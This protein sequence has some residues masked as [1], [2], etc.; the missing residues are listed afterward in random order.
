MFAW[1]ACS[2]RSPTRSALL[3]SPT[4]HCAPARPFYPTGQPQTGRPSSLHPRSLR[5]TPT[6]DPQ[7]DRF[8]FSYFA[9]LWLS[10]TRAPP[11]IRVP[12]S[13]ACRFCLYQ[14]AGPSS[15]S[16]LGSQGKGRA[17]GAGGSG[18]G[19]SAGEGGTASEVAYDAWRRRAGGRGVWFFEYVYG[20]RVE[21]PVFALFGTSPVNL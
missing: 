3:H 6:P 21:F 11:G 14:S 4:L 10:P 1:H 13:H 15:S 7:A 17:G 2:S 16:A 20:R 8:R 12:A 19:G 9:T 18:A 5:T